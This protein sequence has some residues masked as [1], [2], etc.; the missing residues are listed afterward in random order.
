MDVAPAPLP[1][2]PILSKHARITWSELRGDWT[3]RRGTGVVGQLR[4]FEHEGRFVGYLV[5]VPGAP[6]VGIV[7][8]RE[9]AKALIRQVEVFSD[10]S[11]WRAQ[12]EMQEH[13]GI[14]DAWNCNDEKGDDDGDE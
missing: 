5:E 14:D 12:Q 11:A 3:A 8:F 2:L 10:K 13:L 1:P 4:R 6:T 7:D 9:A